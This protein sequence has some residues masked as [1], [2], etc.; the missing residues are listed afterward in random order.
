MP[1][2][3]SISYIT[4]E[5]YLKA[6]EKATIR[7]EYVDGRIFAMT[8]STKNHVVIC[9][10]IALLLRGFL[11]GSQCRAFMNDIKVHSVSMNSYYYPDVMVSC[12]KY[13]GNDVVEE[14]PRLLVEVLSR[15]TAAIDRRE[16]MLAYRQIETLKEYLIVHQH[17]RKLELH[18]KCDDGAWSSFEL[19]PGTCT[20]FVL[21]SLPVGP[22]KVSFADIY[23]GVEFTRKRKGIVGEEIAE[24]YPAGEEDDDF[25]SENEGDEDDGE[26]DW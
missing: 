8:G 10:N 9:M 18:R 1:G 16:K 15:S 19:L 24:Y 6:E 2:P 17:R 12:G 20:D 22:I 21:E 23:E 25:L 26:L 5:E 4:P 13:R 3:R 14:Q 11:K 7:H